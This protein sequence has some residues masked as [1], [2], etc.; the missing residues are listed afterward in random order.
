[1]L[2]DPPEGDVTR[3]VLCS[4]KIAYD[5]LAERARRGDRSTAVVRLEE[6]YPLPD[7]ALLALFYR[8]PHAVCRWVQ[9]E[10]RNMGA[11]SW[12]DRRIAAIR[13]RAGAAQ[14]TMAYIGR[15]EA[16]APA[17]SFHGDHEDEQARIVSDALAE[18]R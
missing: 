9:E 14:P 10:P 16:G 15:A 13:L 7:A 1:M 11:W 8:H 3:L 5:L 18:E 17:G 4:G 6:L 12:L 2:V